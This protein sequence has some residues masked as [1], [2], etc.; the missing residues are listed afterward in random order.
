MRL[1]STLSRVIYSVFHRTWPEQP[2]LAQS[3]A[4]RLKQSHMRSSLRPKGQRRL[5]DLIL[6]S[7]HHASPLGSITILGGNHVFINDS[8]QAVK[9]IGVR[10]K[11]LS[12]HR[13][14][15]FASALLYQPRASGLHLV[16][17]FSFERGR[18]HF[19]ERVSL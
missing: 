5:F 11:S 2:H 16:L 7:R 4:T 18:P 8:A 10:V 1:Q 6:Y 19:V 3:C 15:T 17:A 14:W 13:K 12:S 9:A